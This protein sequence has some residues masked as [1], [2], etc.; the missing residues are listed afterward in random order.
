VSSK[1]HRVFIYERNLADAEKHGIQY[2]PFECHN[3]SADTLQKI[4]KEEGVT[5]QPGDI[6]LI[7]FGYTRA[8]ESF[9]DGKR[10]KI[11]NSPTLA[12]GVERSEATLRFFYE[13]HFAAVVGDNI[14]LE[15][16]CWVLLCCDRAQAYC[17]VGPVARHDP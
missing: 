13:N 4:A 11:A 2:D 6:L 14:A 3:V 10:A 16:R 17:P 1:S 12:I 9:E 8:W 7:R 15:V 5:F